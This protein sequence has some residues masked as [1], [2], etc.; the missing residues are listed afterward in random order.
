MAYRMTPTMS[1]GRSGRNTYTDNTHVVHILVSMKYE[2]AHTCVHEQ[3]PII[4]DECIAHIIKEVDEIHEGICE[5]SEELA[6]V[7][8]LHN[9]AFFEHAEETIDNMAHTVDTLHE[10]L[11]NHK[12]V[13]VSGAP[14]FDHV[15]QAL[16]T[17]CKEL[18]AEYH[19]LVE[20]AYELNLISES[21][22]KVLLRG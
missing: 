17:A 6:P 3:E 7:V 16:H 14:L 1:S 2:I 11:R 15:K 9:G 20:D 22:K 13:H 8:H 21:T 4:S 19:D 5:L 10:A 12:R 18:H